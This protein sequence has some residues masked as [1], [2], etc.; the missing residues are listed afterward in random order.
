LNLFPSLVL[1]LIF[2]FFGDLTSTPLLEDNLL[3]T[4]KV[5]IASL[6]LRFL[7]EVTDEALKP[8]PYLAYFPEERL[9][10]RPEEPCLLNLFSPLLLVPELAKAFANELTDLMERDPLSP[11]L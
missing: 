4:C 5:F 3:F 2:C 6:A 10:L 7:A 1:G 8:E 11:E 9:L